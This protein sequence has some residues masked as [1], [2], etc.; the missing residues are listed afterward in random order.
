MNKPP[1]LVSLLAIGLSATLVGGC[2]RHPA[3][4]EASAQ[5]DSAQPDSD[6]DE[7]L[8][9]EPIPVVSVVRKAEDQ[10]RLWLPP[11]AANIQVRDVPYAE[12]HA[13]VAAGREHG[14]EALG[15]EDLSVLLPAAAQLQ[16]VQAAIY[17][18]AVRMRGEWTQMK[19]QSFLTD[20]RYHEVLNLS[21]DLQARINHV[22]HQQWLWA[23]AT[24]AQ[25]AQPS[26]L[27]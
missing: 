5:T 11:V 6:G 9:V 17:A 21:N 23:G 2:Q 15:S 4:P 24:S 27:P 18:L 26:E 22:R 13:F 3:P 12:I 14:R 16:E 7:A 25:P 20:L 10:T 8:Q 19:Y 1:L